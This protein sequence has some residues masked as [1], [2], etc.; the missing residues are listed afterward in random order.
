MQPNQTS[1]KERISYGLSDTASNLVYQM[2]IMYLMFFYTDVYGLSVA[3]VGTL[4]LAAR[5]IDAFD[6]P[7]FGLLID[8]TQ[9]KWGKSRPWIIWMAIP[10]SISAILAFSTPN[11]SETGK[12]I[13]AYVT[14]IILGICYAGVNIPIT[15]ILPSMT[16]NIN[17]RNILVSVRMVLA[18]VGVTIVSMGTLP[19]VNLLGNGSQQQGFMRTMIFYA[20]LAFIFLC[21]S[22]KNIRERVISEKGD[23]ALPI[24]TALKAVKGNVPLYILFFVAFIYTIGFV[25]KMQTTVYYLTY[26]LGRAELV[27][28]VLGLSS[29]NVISYFLMPF[30]AKLMGKRNIMILG[31]SFMVVAQLSFYFANSEWIFLVGTTIGVIGQGFFQGAVFTMIA[32]IVD[33]GEWKSGIRAQGIV[34]TI[35]TFSFKIGLGLGGALSA[36]ILSAGHYIA[37]EK[38]STQA[39]MAIEWSFIWIPLVCFIAGIIALLFYKL[40]KQATQMIEELNLRRGN[41]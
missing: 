28:V 38:Q 17:E 5:V 37:G 2:I 1:W 16:S 13:Y 22:F 30:L 27:G 41:N 24:K 6:S 34:S 23:E 39:L 31:L 35:P 18:T 19:L 10:F 11:F 9:T 33:Y 3:T 12:V 20:V 25:M 15:S 40:D 32:D 29:L 7:I 4:F 26:N 8:R 36:W 21:I 14:Y